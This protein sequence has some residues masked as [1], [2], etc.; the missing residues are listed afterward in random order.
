MFDN[1]IPPAV[2]HWKTFNLKQQNKVFSK[3]IYRAI[4]NSYGNEG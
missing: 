1:K 4:D 3:A 2:Q